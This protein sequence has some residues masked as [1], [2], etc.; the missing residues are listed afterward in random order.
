[1]T[2][3]A[4]ITEQTPEQR[5][6]ET[7]RRRAEAQ[8]SAVATEIGQLAE[9]SRVAIATRDGQI[10]A[11]IG[12]RLSHQRIADL[13]SVHKSNVGQREARHVQLQAP[14]PAFDEAALVEA[15]ALAKTIG[16]QRAAAIARRDALIYEIHDRWGVQQERLAHLAQMTAQQ[17]SQVMAARPAAPVAAAEG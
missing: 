7:E 16:D 13:A 5:R 2:Q 11:A 12:A 3:E 14:V 6:Q 8:L 10:V 4:A 17:M 1:M 15:G 9:R